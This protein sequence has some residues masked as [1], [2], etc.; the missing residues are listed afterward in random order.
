METTAK[1][2]AQPIRTTDGQQDGYYMMLFCFLLSS[3]QHKNAFNFAVVTVDSVTSL[4]QN[5]Y[6]LKM[7]TFYH[8]YTLV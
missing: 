7:V 6:I 3:W 5:L 1:C 4:K 2:N 8:L